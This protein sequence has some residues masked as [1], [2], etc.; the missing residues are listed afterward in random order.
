MTTLVLNQD[1]NP[2]SFLPLSI[3]SWEESIKYMVLDK[4]HVLEWYDDWIV[5]SATWETPVPAVIMLREYMKQKVSIRFSKQNVF[6]RDG[7][8]CVYCNVEVNKKTATLDHVIPTS[9][10]G[11]TTFENTVCACNDCNARKGNNKKIVP[12]FKPQKPNYFQLVEKRK[13]MR[14]DLAHPSWSLYLGLGQ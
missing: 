10:G 12:K 7:Y 4:A 14:F 8:H 1:G 2:V 9:H 3:I 6:L 5:H 13:K 11:K